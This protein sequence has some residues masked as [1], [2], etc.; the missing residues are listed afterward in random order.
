MV[1]GSAVIVTIPAE[2]YYY[3]Q[4]PMERT[5]SSGAGQN[6]L[7]LS[8]F[9][10]RATLKF[11]N[12]VLERTGEE[13]EIQERM[14]AEAMCELAESVLKKNFHWKDFQA[15]AGEYYGDSYLHKINTSMESLPLDLKVLNYF[16]MRKEFRM[17][18]FLSNVRKILVKIKRA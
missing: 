7:A 14:V 18:W 10:C 1:S 17:M 5:L 8:A 9:L 12:D 6:K 16:F 4:N 11:Y 3:I 2:L 15:L 13:K